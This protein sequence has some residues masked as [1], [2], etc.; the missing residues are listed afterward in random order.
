MDRPQT[1]LH[2][3]FIRLYVITD[4]LVSETS[5]F[6]T[7]KNGTVCGCSLRTYFSK[8]DRRVR[9]PGPTF[10]SWPLLGGLI[11]L[12]TWKSEDSPPVQIDAFFKTVILFPESDHLP[13]PFNNQYPTFPAVAAS[14]LRF[15]RRFP[16][17]FD[18]DSQ[19]WDLNVSRT[20]GK[21]TF[22]F[23]RFFFS[24]GEFSHVPCNIANSPR[25]K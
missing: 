2:L 20:N 5:L 7:P 23:L 9:K 6:V 3:Y 12:Q 11:Q 17:Q 8:V 13:P 24:G 21:L 16:F 19:K 14:E 15:A 18:L 25:G 22:A 1:P 10:P 4:V